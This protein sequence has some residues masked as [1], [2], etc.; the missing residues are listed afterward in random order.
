M[1]ASP[2]SASGKSARL[3]LG[4][5]LALGNK[6]TRSS[7]RAVDSSDTLGPRGRREWP[8]YSGMRPTRTGDLNPRCTSPSL[9]GLRA[10]K[11]L[12]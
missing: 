2:K 12:H 11:W 8:V 1:G 5:A 9:L 7:F 10:P 3:L 4:N 6:G